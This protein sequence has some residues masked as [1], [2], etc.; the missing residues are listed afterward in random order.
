MAITHRTI[1]QR[2][3]TGLRQMRRAYD[4]LLSVREQV[5]PEEI[6]LSD[7]WEADLAPVLRDLYWHPFRNGFSQVPDTAGKLRRWLTAQYTEEAT[8]PLRQ[9]MQRYQVKAANL[10]GN[11]AL[12][13]MG[14]DGSFGLTNADY[15]A[16]LTDHAVM[17]TSQGTEMSLIDT[18]IDDLV[19]GILKANQQLRALVDGV[20]RIV[21]SLITGWTAVRSA[22][23]AITETTRQ[24]A[25]G[26]IWTFTENGIRW[27]EFVTREDRRVCQRC[28]P[29]HGQRM[30]V[31]AIPSELR[32]PV[33]G[34]CRCSYRAVLTDWA[35]PPLIWT[36]G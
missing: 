36:G 7:Q 13:Q 15:L 35:P 27:Q 24:V 34:A 31:D 3:Y 22:L 2:L 1:D 26:L 33:H 10:G 11:I 6:A 14:I 17:M 9:L 5:T 20:F 25:N 12:E 19:D 8:R 21:S 18:T 23:I 28:Q 29:L 32:L 16:A 30:R 4:A